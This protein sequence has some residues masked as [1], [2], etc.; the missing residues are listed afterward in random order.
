VQNFRKKAGKT[1]KDLLAARAG[2]PTAGEDEQDTAGVDAWVKA[3]RGLDPDLA[4]DLPHPWLVLAGPGKEL[5]PEQFAARRQELAG[6]LRAPAA[7]AA[8]KD[9]VTGGAR[10]SISGGS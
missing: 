1:A 10:A 8:E 5:T 7:R 4:D 3:L 9:S 2:D 6:R